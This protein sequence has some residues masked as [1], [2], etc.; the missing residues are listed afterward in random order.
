MENEKQISDLQVGDEVLVHS[1]HRIEHIDKITKTT[2]TQLCI[3]DIKFRKDDGKQV[4][5]SKR[6]VGYITIPTEEDRKRVKRE[7]LER[8][9]KAMILF[10]SETTEQLSDDELATLFPIVLNIYKRLKITS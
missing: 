3:N 4:G 5:L 10:I 2:D 6:D 7:K 1:T 9:L 8:N